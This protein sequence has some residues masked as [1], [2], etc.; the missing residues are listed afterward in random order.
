MNADEFRK[1]A[2]A[3]AGVS[4]GSHQGH[5]DFRVDG[6]VFATLGPDEDWAMVKLTPDV[7]SSSVAAEPDVFEPF[8]GAWGKQGCTRVALAKGRGS[9]IEVALVSAWRHIAPESLV[10]R[11]DEEC[12]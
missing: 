3:L 2:L 9:V 5:A 10:R 1:L 11:H 4:E 6:C 7:Q 8:N 12:T